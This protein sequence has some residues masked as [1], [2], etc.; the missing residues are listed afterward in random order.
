MGA[1]FAVRESCT[2]PVLVARGVEAVAAGEAHTLFIRNTRIPVIVTQPVAQTVPPGGTATLS[3]AATGAWPVFQWYRGAPGDVTNPVEGA[4]SSTF[5]IPRMVAGSQFWVRVSNAH[6]SDDSLAVWVAVAGAT[7]GYSSWIAA[8]A[9][10][11]AAQR[12]ALATPAGDGVCNFLK[13]ALGAQPMDRIDD[14]APQPT[15]VAQDG[16]AP[17]LAVEFTRN[18]CAVDVRWILELS[19]DLKHWTETPATMSILSTNPDGSQRVR[20]CA[21]STSTSADRGFARLKVAPWP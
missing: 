14:H 16:S 4:S 5:T 6:G 3:V 19:P 7:G 18:P 21:D 12:G 17:A 11:P 9:E 15:L 1:G 13:Y 20:L 10:V 8:F 2:N